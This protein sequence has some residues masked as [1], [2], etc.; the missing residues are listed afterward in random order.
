MVPSDLKTLIA[1]HHRPG[2]RPSKVLEKWIK[3]AVAEVLSLQ[4]DGHSLRTGSFQWDD[5]APVPPLDEE[6]G[7]LPL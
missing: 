4:T 7:D 1:K 5:A 6:D 2:K 3:R